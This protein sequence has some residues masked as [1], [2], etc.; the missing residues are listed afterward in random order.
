MEEKTDIR[1][2]MGVAFRS[3]EVEIEKERGRKEQEEGIKSER[4]QARKN[5]EVIKSKINELSELLK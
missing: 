4:E 2:D 3:I 1:S 5:L